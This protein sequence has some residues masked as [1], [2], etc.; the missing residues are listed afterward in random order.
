MK[1]NSNKNAKLKQKN[2]REFPVAFPRSQRDFAEISFHP[3]LGD[4]Q[5][6]K[7]CTPHI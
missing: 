6:K 1:I 2:H 3:V 5:S 7:I 4:S